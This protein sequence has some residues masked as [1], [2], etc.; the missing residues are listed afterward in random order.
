LNVSADIK[1]TG[2]ELLVGVDFNIVPMSAVIGV[3]AGNQLHIIDEITIQ[4]GNTEL[5]SEA[6]QRKFPARRV[7]VYPDPSGKARKTSSPVGQTDFSILAAH[8]FRVLSGNAAPLVVDRCNEVNAM[9]KNAAGDR[10]LIVHSRCK[11][12]IKCLD[13]LTFKEGTSQPDKDMGLDHL[14]DALGYLVHYEYPISQRMNKMV[15]TGI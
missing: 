2:A 3:K 8:G 6:I 12:L 11:Q 9:L 15:L 7:Q 4:N 14:P 1:D 10:R 5:I 13:G